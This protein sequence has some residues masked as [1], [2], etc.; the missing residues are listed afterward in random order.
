MKDEKMKP[1]VFV[2]PKTTKG[3]IT[4]L[5]FLIIILISSVPFINLVN[6]PV[7]VLGMPLLML[8]SIVI[9]LLVVVVLRLALKWGV[10]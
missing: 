4:A 10:K 2:R 3:K 1:F 8:W 9:V 7:L 6:K 5:L